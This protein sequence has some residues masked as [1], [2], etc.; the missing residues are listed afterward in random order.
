[1]LINISNV[2]VFK[3]QAYLLNW[4][5]KIIE[6]LNFDPIY[7]G[8]FG[9]VDLKKAPAFRRSGAQTPVIT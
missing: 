1:M 2:C 4:Q 7:L 6:I 9:S 8:L 5:L 3:N